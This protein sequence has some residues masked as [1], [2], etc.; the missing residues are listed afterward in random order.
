MAV[1]AVMAWY[2]CLGLLQLNTLAPAHQQLVGNAWIILHLLEIASSSPWTDAS[3]ACAGRMGGRSAGLSV[4]TLGS[5]PSLK[6]AAA[7]L[8]IGS[9]RTARRA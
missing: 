8:K 7:R 5:P 6:P 4:W 3:T 2:R 9:T 1:L